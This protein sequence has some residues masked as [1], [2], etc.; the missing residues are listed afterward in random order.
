MSNENTTCDQV[1]MK[2]GVFAGADGLRLL[3]NKDSFWQDMPYETRMYFGPE[4]NEYLHRGVLQTAV[5][6]IE[7]QGTLQGQINELHR[8]LAGQQLRADQGWSR[9]QAANAARLDTEAE[10]VAL[11]A[12]CLLWKSDAE[13]WRKIAPHLVVEN[14]SRDEMRECQ[15]AVMLKQGQLNVPGS[16]YYE[17]VVEAIDSMPA[18]TLDRQGAVK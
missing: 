4:V 7:E 1:L 18:P 10:L 3:A 2:S 12:E 8:Q 11:K 6:V 9:H 14:H 17:S 5:R 13:R 16:P 15:S